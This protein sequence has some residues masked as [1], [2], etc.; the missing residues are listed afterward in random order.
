MWS[1]EADPA[2]AALEAPLKSMISA[3]LFCTLGVNSLIFQSVSIK[4]SAGLPPMLQF[5]TSGYIVGEWFPQIAICLIAVTG[6]LVF[7]ASWV[8]DLLWSRRVMAVKF[9]LGMP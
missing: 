9:S 8:R 2:E 6:E 7:K 1:I 3:P 4:S 5:L